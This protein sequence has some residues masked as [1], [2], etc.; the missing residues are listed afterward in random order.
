MFRK[1][2]LERFLRYVVVDT[3]SI[4]PL[5]ETRHPSFDGEWDLLKLLEKEL[6][7]TDFLRP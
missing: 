3:M 2:I 5:A 7:A 4:E 1:E 6:R